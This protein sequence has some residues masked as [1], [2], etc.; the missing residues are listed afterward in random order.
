MRE[1]TKLKKPVML[2][3]KIQE[4][5]KWEREKQNNLSLKNSKLF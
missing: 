2:K 3:N 4:K 5:S 1:E